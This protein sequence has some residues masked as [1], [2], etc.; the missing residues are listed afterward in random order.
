MK[1]QIIEKFM[2]AQQQADKQAT[3]QALYELCLLLFETTH[4]K[5]PTQFMNLVLAEA[6]EVCMNTMING[7]EVW[8]SYTLPKLWAK[9][10]IKWKDKLTSFQTASFPIYYSVDKPVLVPQGQDLEQC[11]DEVASL[12]NQD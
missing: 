9:T 12:M 10:I 3:E 11:I 6:V 2:A 5:Q 7:V 1:E 8:Q 4:H